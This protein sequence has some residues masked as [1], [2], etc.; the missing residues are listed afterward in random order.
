M[1]ARVSATTICPRH[2][3]WVNAEGE[4]GILR[5]AGSMV[6]GK[7][8]CFELEFCVACRCYVD[9]SNTCSDSKLSKEESPFNW[10][11]QACQGEIFTVKSVLIRIVKVKS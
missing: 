2:Y 9:D 6:F 3:S 1:Q 8:F 4:H 10:S 5:N 11:C 7:F